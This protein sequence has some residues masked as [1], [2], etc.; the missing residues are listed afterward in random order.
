MIKEPI[1]G[2]L[3]KMVEEPI[4]KAATRIADGGWI[5]PDCGSIR[6]ISADF[7][8]LEDDKV[9]EHIRCADCGCDDH[10]ARLHMRISFPEMKKNG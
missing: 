4:M 5:C 3:D 9:L 2:L 6:F 8:L 10:T 1:K 7:Y